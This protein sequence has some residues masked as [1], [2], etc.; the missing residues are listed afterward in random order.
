MYLLGCA[1]AGRRPLMAYEFSER[2]YRQVK[3][4]CLFAILA[5][6]DRLGTD[7]AVHE[8]RVLVRE[9]A[10]DV[11]HL[12]AVFR[13]GMLRQ[14]AT[15]EELRQAP[16]LWPEEYQEVRVLLLEQIDDIW[17]TWMLA[18]PVQP[19]SEHGGYLLPLHR[20]WCQLGWYP[21]LTQ[22]DQAVRH[23]EVTCAPRH[24]L[25]LLRQCDGLDE[26][27][28]PGTQHF[29]RSRSLNS[30]VPVGGGG[31]ADARCVRLHG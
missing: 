13:R 10:Q 23:M 2:Q 20:R 25:V 9:Q 27:V 21:D 7:R 16:S 4:H 3:Q 8:G 17:Q 14:G 29:S 12:P 15:F 26:S 11:A 30:H 22:E 28:A 6:D 18:Q 19:L 24:A 5:D 1:V 31:L